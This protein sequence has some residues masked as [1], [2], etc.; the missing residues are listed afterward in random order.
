[1]TATKITAANGN[2]S[3][4]TDRNSELAKQYAANITSVS[5]TAAQPWVGINFKADGTVVGGRTMQESM[6]N[7]AIEKSRAAGMNVVEI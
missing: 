7:Q 5:S 1:M 6:R 2:Y 3:I 4:I